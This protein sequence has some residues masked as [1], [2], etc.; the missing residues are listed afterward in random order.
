MNV[1]AVGSCAF[2]EIAMGLRELRA[3][4]LDGVCEAV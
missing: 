2:G 4:K 3:S 1:L